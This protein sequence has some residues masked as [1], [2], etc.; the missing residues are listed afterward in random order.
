VEQLA[1]VV[2]MQA[3]GMVDYLRNVKGAATAKWKLE[4]KEKR[5]R[6]LPLAS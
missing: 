4:F 6:R 3:V 2:S 1:I 5:Y